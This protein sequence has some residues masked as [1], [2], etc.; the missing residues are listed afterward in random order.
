MFMGLPDLM[1][2]GWR[3][4]RSQKDNFILLDYT[5]RDILTALDYTRRSYL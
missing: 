3:V 2:V 5:E 1:T 4:G